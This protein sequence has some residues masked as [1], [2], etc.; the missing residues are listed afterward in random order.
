MTAHDESPGPP[1]PLDHIR[2]LDFTRHLAGAG[3]TRILGTLGAQVIRI[4]WPHYPAL[5]FLRLGAASLD[6]IPGVDRGGFFAQ[7]NVEKQSIAIDLSTERGR[8]IVRRLV[9][10]CDVVIESFSPGVM[11]KWGFNYDAFRTLREDLVYVAASGF[12]HAGPYRNYRSYGPTAQAFGGLTAT[13]GLADREPSG[14]GFSYMDHMG[15][16]TAAAAMLMALEHRRRTGRGEF[17][18]AAQC[19]DGCVLLGPMLLDA[20][21]NRRKIRPRGN[22]DLYR[23]S[24][25]NNAYRCRGEDR[26]CTISIRGEEDWG[27]L[28]TA[29]GDPPWAADPALAT[30]AGRLARE[31]EIDSRI[32]AWTQEREADAVMETLQRQGVPAGVTQTVQEKLE[33]DPQLAHR[34]FYA[35]LDHPILGPRPYEGIPV[36]MSGFGVGPHVRSPRLGEHTRDVLRDLLN[37][38]EATLEALLRDAVIADP[39]PLSADGPP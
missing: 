19:R 31:D 16:A 2:I 38:S 34:N 9:P 18:D 39:E 15:A 29:M 11:S 7:C 37:F 13:A 26:W 27:G 4:E 33:R 22:R 1:R 12:G 17:I 3:A 30:L 36:R 10:H 25:P 14:W 28:R 23:N 21:L 6:G 35:T 20:A 24:C 8:D 32:E 5:D